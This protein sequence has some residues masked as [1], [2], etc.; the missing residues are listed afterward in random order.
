MFQKYE[1]DVKIMLP[2]DKTT[3]KINIQGFKKIILTINYN[4]T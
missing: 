3:K 1:L 2:K 4:I